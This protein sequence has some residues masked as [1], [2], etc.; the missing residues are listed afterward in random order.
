MPLISFQMSTAFNSL[1]KRD[2]PSPEDWQEQAAL[3]GK[4]TDYLVSRCGWCFRQKGQ[5]F[6]S[7]IRSVVVR[8]FF[9]LL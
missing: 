1:A 7:S 4:S 5:N 6:F 2:M 9:V 3:A 8:L